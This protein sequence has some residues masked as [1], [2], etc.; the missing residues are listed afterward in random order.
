MYNIHCIYTLY[1]YTVHI[2]ISA[3]SPL[4]SCYHHAI[5]IL[6]IILSSSYHHPIIILSSSLTVPEY[7]YYRTHKKYFKS[8]SWKLK[9]V[10]G[11]NQQPMENCYGALVEPG[12]EI[13]LP[14][15]M[16]NKG[17]NVDTD[18]APQWRWQ[19]PTNSV[20]DMS[21]WMLFKNSRSYPSTS[22]LYD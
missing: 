7:L 22:Y 18:S 20:G 21:S 12:L 6:F 1:I 11:G 13:P 14:W 17:L 5:I 8:Q 3:L 19:S 2:Y 15:N 4:S 10:W 16:G 9:L